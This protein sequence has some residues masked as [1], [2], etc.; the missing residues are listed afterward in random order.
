MTEVSG[1]G[2]YFDPGGGTKYCDEYVGLSLHSQLKNHVVKFHQI[3]CACCM[4]LRLGPL[5]ALQYVMHFWFY[6]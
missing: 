6:G 4:W 5:M 2:D 3:F 1:V